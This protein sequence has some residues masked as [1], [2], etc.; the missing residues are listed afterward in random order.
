MSWGTTRQGTIEEVRAQLTKEFEQI[1]SNYPPGTLEGDDV[2]AA[3]E[4]VFKLLDALDTTSQGYG[5]EVRV[6]ANG[7]HGWSNEGKEHPVYGTFNV[8]VKRVSA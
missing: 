5:P 6:D 3:K 4:R 7:S 8:S 2:Q 1:A